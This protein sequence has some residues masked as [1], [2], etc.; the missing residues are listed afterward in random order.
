MF[1]TSL[2][3]WPAMTVLAFVAL[4][5]CVPAP[6]ING[7]QSYFHFVSQYVGIWRAGTDERCNLASIALLLGA[8]FVFAAAL[9]WFLHI[10]VL[11]LE[12][13]WRRA[14]I[15]NINNK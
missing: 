3:L 14:D 9:G 7:R 6:S 10:V 13:K 5:L 8:W 11:T 1:L 15:D 2:W 4:G 12:A